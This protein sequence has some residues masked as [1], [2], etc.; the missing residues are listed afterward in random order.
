MMTWHHFIGCTKHP[1]GDWP[2]RNA[3][4][5]KSSFSYGSAEERE[6]ASVRVCV[7]RESLHFHLQ[8]LGSHYRIQREMYSLLYALAPSWT[9]VSVLL[10]FTLFYVYSPYLYVMD[11][12]W[13]GFRRQ[14]CCLFSY[15]SQLLDLFCQESWSL[16]LSYQMALVS[17]IAAMV[18][19]SFFPFFFILRCFNF[20]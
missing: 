2:Q 12:F 15:T 9:S 5:Q 14:C 6:R 8:F 7:Q 17:I 13:R 20:L 10:F 1:M 4:E 3:S 18:G 16:E 19:P 11:C